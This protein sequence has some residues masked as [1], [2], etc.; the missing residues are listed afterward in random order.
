MATVC[1]HSATFGQTMVPMLTRRRI[2]RGQKMPFWGSDGQTML[3]R[4]ANLWVKSQ[5]QAND[6]YD[7]ERA[8]TFRSRLDRRLYDRYHTPV[9]WEVT[10]TEDAAATPCPRAA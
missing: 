1:F 5:R 8:A 2:L 7:A 6:L 3:P 9:A 4:L 10:P